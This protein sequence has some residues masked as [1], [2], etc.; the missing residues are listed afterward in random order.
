MI[1]VQSTYEWLVAGCP[2]AK[3]APQ[4]VGELAERLVRDGIPIER[5][6]A[7][8]RTLHPNVFGRSFFWAKGK[9]TE[10][11]EGSYALTR[12]PEFQKSPAMV[13]G[14]TGKRIR[15]RIESEE[16][17]FDSV[18]DLRREGFTDWM[19]EPM[20]FLSGEIHAISF[21]TK[22]KGGFTDEMIAGIER[23]VPPLTRIAE[24]LALSR[25]AANLLDAYVGPNAGS[26]IL[27]GKIQLGDTDLIK[28]AIWFSDLRGFTS[29]SAELQPGE[30]IAMLNEVFGCQVPAIE[31]HGGE[32]LKF[33]GDGMLAIFPVGADSATAC[34]HA[35]DAAQ[36]AF[37][38]LE[39]L[40]VDRQKR[41]LKA[42]AF[43]VGLHLGEVA[44]GNIGGS[45]RMDFTCIGQAVNL[46]SRIESCAGKLSRP[47]VVSADL[48]RA[49]TRKME[50][51]GA[52]ELKGV[53]GQTEVFAPAA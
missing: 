28:A 11:R 13:V 24:V 44:Y 14:T 38:A 47:M 5:L 42:V 18:R 40:N 46:A 7:F 51:V 21:A 52:Y 36:E 49:T 35:L 23:V 15:F 45:N 34:D 22:A 19:M 31:H 41:G 17:P 30:L 3:G 32:V 27:S 37:G 4:V 53:P 29:M 26:K 8:V 10:V 50:R 1:D 25:T 43:G 2:G 12:S 39:K 9:A 48:A 20:T 6:A 16:T 33:M